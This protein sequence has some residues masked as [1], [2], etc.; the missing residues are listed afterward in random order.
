METHTHPVAVV[1][2]G[3][4]HDVAGAEVTDFV[5]FIARQSGS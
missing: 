1:Y 2:R 5:A 3:L 4:G